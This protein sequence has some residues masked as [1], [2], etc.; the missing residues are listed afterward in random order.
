MMSLLP[1]MAEFGWRPEPASSLAGEVDALFWSMTG[2]SVLAMTLL[3]IAWLWLIVRFR[4]S[5]QPKAKPIGG[6]VALEIVWSLIPLVVFLG[7]FFWGTDLYVR[8]RKVPT[9]AREI[10]V[11]GKQWMWKIHHPEGAREI[12]TLHVP[13]GVPIKLVMTSEDVIHN[14]FIPAF[15]AKMD[16]LPGRYTTM[17]FEA[18]KVG[19]YR[20]F[21][22]EF[23]GTNHATMGGWV[24][25]MEPQEYQAWLA[26]ERAK[27]EPPEKIGERLFA[28][29]GCNTC[30]QSDNAIVGP[31]L[32]GKWDKEV[33]LE[34]GG[35]VLFDL[36]YLRESVR[37]PN[38]KHSQGFG[39]A[40]A[41]MP[42]YGS[43]QLS[44][45]DLIKLAAYLRSIGAG[46]AAGG[47]E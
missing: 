6:S 13:V 38:A 21:C 35:K 9:D 46:A 47:S 15:R 5:A 30:H 2:I 39:G 32:H 17:W 12:N 26:G 31:T 20:L 14:F 37:K 8:Q 34:G 1:L 44:E 33:P 23:C 42:A 7:Y 36:A 40:R 24:H 16:V 10:T 45:D 43:S 18:T 25:V 3:T 4:R 22:A 28:S 11:V 19:K 41:V 27:A 29:L